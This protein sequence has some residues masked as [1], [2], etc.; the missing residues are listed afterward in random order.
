MLEKR[1]QRQRLVAKL[2]KQSWI[3]IRGNDLVGVL[4][5]PPLVQL[6]PFRVI[7]LTDVSMPF[8]A[9]SFPKLKF[10]SVC[11]NRAITM[12][13]LRKVIWSCPLFQL[14]A[15]EA[16]LCEEHFESI[17]KSKPFLRFV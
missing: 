6:V 15:S 2:G 11:Y 7:S 3:Q 13:G 17:V 5:T 1:V 12:A 8:I 4:F 16:G 10:L 14:E 9:S